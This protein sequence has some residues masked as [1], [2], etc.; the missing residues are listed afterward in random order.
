MDWFFDLSSPTA[1]ATFYVALSTA[2]PG[3]DGS[4]ISEP[5]GNG[6][7]RIEAG[8]G[9][10]NWTRTDDSVVNDNVITFSE[11]SGSWGT[12]THFALFTAVT[13]G[14]FLGSG[15]LDSPQAI[16]T[17]QT[18]SFPAGDLEVTLT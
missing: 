14:T 15:E 7:A 9:T 10:D 17:G 8:T 2:D 5:S 16:T 13:A 12:L 4:S 3:E 18:A 6:Y 11:A 1:P